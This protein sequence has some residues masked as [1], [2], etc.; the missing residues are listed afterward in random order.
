ME[1]FHA[2]RLGLKDV[3]DVVRVDSVLTDEPLEDMKT[4]WSE[5]VDAAFL[6]EIGCRIDGVFDET[7][8][9]EMLAHGFGH[10][11]RHRE[12]GRR[13]GGNDTRRFPWVR[14]TIGL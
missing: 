8:I 7:S 9:H 3:A 2:N 12:G 10:L 13:C 1:K 11:T 6:E 14:S 4:L 5:L